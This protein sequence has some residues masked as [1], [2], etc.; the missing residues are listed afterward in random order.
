MEQ[1]YAVIEIPKSAAAEYGV[2]VREQ[3]EFEL[4]DESEADHG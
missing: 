1:D 3:A 4:E 2:D